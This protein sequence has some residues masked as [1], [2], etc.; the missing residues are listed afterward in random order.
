MVLKYG[1]LLV[2]SSMSG[3]YYEYLDRCTEHFLIM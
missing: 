3:D 2:G 1:V